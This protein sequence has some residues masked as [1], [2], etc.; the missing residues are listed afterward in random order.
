MTTKKPTAAN[1]RIRAVKAQPSI[2]ARDKQL[3]PTK[4]GADL[5]VKMEAFRQAL[6]AQK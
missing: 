2:P 3:K 4:W 5:L 1:S 6:A